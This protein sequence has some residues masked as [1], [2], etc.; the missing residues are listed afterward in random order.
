MDANITRDSLD[1]GMLW[2]DVAEL[3]W[4]NV[5]DLSDKGAHG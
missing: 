3:S 4:N 1:A 2:L 5:P